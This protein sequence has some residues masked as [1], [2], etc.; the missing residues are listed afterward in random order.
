MPIGLLGLTNEKN[1]IS[2]NNFHNKL[3]KVNMKI[4]VL[5]WAAAFYLG[6]F[7]LPNLYNSREENAFSD[8]IRLRE[9]QNEYHID[10][11]EDSVVIVPGEFY[12]RGK[13]VK[14]LL[15]SNYRNLWQQEVKVPVLDMKTI[16]GGLAP[17][18]FS[19]GEQTIGIEAE[20]SLGRVWSIRSVN[21]DQAQALSGLFQRSILRP[22]FRDQAS[23]LNP[24]GSLVA[25][26]LAEAIDIHHANPQ[27]YFFPYT[28]G[29]GK[30][31]ERMAGRLVTLGEEVDEGWSGQP[32][33]D[34]AASI[35]DTDDMWDRLDSISIPIDTTLYAKSRLFDMLISDWDRHEG[36]WKWILT[37]EGENALIEPVPVDRD[38]ALYNFGEGVIN[39]SVSLFLKKFQSFEPEYG[40]IKGLMH[41]SKAIDLAILGGMEKE[42]FIKQAELIQEQ[43]DDQIIE[44]A[45]NNYPPDVYALLGQ[46]HI[47]ILKQRLEKL[48]EVAEEF[49]ELIQKEQE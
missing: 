48:P 47:S 12:K 43:L 38:M 37:E 22:M 16:K 41:Q 15:G 2:L 31:N 34:D 35:L 26:N 25:S 29:F 21:K 24:Y 28:P 45:F 49:Y 39:K 6:F 33:F 4:K 23:S 17:E 3:K 14:S 20:D 7:L 9:A 36:N 32:E 42:E 8:T 27:L 46:E 19:G 18:E 13:L 5:F 1:R 40:S 30:F 11:I 44:A 10:E